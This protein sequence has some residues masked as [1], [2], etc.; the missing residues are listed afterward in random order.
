MTAGHHQES[1]A[2]LTV[3]SHRVMAKGCA[4][5]RR[6][7]REFHKEEGEGSREAKTEDK[8][9]GRLPSRGAAFFQCAQNHLQESQLRCSGVT[10]TMAAKSG[11][12]GCRKINSLF[13][14]E[15][16]VVF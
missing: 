3:A 4:W 1:P 7:A 16:T 15:V 14:T 10:G 2:G 6:S 13:D 5:D 11:G 8:G 12:G 9:F